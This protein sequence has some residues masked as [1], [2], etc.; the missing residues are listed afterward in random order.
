MNE[1]ECRLAYNLHEQFGRVCSREG[2]GAVCGECIRDRD[3]PAMG[4]RRIDARAD[5]R[6]AERDKASEAV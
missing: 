3:A 6:P 1:G 5:F 4:F 2:G